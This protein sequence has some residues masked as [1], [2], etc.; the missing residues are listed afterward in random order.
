MNA[1]ILR[2]NRMVSIILR[3]PDEQDK[4]GL[5]T[6]QT[7]INLYPDTV[8]RIIVNDIDCGEVDSH[9]LSMVINDGLSRR[10]YCR[11]C[12]HKWICRGDSAPQWC[13]KCNSPYWDKLRRKDTARRNRRS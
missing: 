7:Y 1:E 11:R 3:T 10:L 4:H 12:G 13:P 9:I 6:I 8:G 2:T 5:K